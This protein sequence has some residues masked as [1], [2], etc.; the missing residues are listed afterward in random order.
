MRT[1]LHG[2]GSNLRSSD[3]KKNL[4][5]DPRLNGDSSLRSRRQCKSTGE[6]EEDDID[7]GRS[8]LS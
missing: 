6:D 2:R 8:I 1:Y 7:Q 5:E 4:S 3:K